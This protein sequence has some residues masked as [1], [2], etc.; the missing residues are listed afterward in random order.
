M[1]EPQFEE[2]IAN[3]R[4]PFLHPVSLLAT[5]F[6]AGRTPKVPG[7]MGTLAALPFAWLIYEWD[8]TMA[9]L[10]ASLLLF[11]IG[12]P[13]SEAYMRTNRT[14]QDPG[15]IVIDEVAAVWLLLT[16]LPH[17]LAGYIFGFVVFRFFDMYKPWPVSLI[18]DRIMGGFGVMIDDYAAAVYPLTLLALLSFVGNLLGLPL[19]ADLFALL[20]AE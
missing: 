10:A 4:M 5:W 3:H 12:V 2:P 14:Q 20:G 19:Y 8:G 11:L 15:E 1:K 7:T 17:T 13:V 9:L 18:D 6:G 16:A